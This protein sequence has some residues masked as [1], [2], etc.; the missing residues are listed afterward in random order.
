[1][2]LAEFSDTF[3]NQI[4]DRLPD[5]DHRII[6]SEQTVSARARI[7]NRCGLDSRTVLKQ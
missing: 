5:H 2:G 4:E 7:P 1:M 3:A 6:D